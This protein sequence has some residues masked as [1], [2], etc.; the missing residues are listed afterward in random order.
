LLKATNNEGRKY[1]IVIEQLNYLH[2]E[3]IE[4]I[5]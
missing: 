1:S 5:I 2:T 4:V 3:K